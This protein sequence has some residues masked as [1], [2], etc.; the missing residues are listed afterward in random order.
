MN[1]GIGLNY[2]KMF[3]YFSFRMHSSGFEVPSGVAFSRIRKYAGEMAVL[4]Q[5]FN[6]VYGMSMLTQEL[7]MIV[8]VVV[9]TTFA[10]LHGSQRSLVMASTLFVICAYKT[11]GTMFEESR[12]TLES[13]KREGRRSPW[14]RRYCR[15][16]RP[17]RVNIG[18][19][20]YADKSLT[21]TI[22]SIMLDYTASMALTIQ[23]N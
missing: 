12:A 23:Q 20:F 9:N 4:S 18:S 2:S 3:C 22:L 1:H 21:L 11:Y 19:F 14:L 10:L 6:A 8:A 17:P 5:H 16:Y 7:L 15:A 13:W